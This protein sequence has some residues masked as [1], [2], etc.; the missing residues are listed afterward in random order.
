ML[1]EAKHQPKVL[2]PKNLSTY[3]KNQRTTDTE[4]LTLL[5]HGLPGYSRTAGPLLDSVIHWF[6]RENNTW[7]LQLK[8]VLKNL[9]QTPDS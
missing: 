8:K 3:R 4:N 2:N 6:C 7:V 1:F 5:T 9:P